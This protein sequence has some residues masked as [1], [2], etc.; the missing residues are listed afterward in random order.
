[1]VVITIFLLSRVYQYA[2][3][4]NQYPVGLTIGGVD[5][6]GM[7]REQASEIIANRYIEAPVVISHQKNSF[8][9]PPSRAEFKLDLTTMLSEADFQ[10]TQQDFWAGFWGYLWGRPVEVAPIA[11]D[12]TYSQT[13]LTDFLIEIS[14]LTDEPAQPPQPVPRTLTFQYGT[15]GTKTN[16]E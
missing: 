9:L 7:T 10:R 15:S 12:A 3:S 2:G 13:A 6:S 5:I 16:I 1:M 8:D 11:L 4:R 14:S